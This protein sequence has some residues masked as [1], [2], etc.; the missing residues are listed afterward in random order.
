MKKTN[1]Y[2]KKAVYSLIF[3]VGLLSVWTVIALIVNDDYSM[4]SIIK[5][6]EDMFKIFYVQEF[7]F[8]YFSTLLRAGIGFA[9]SFIIGFLL[10]II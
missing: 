10:A 1:T 9:C 8:A 7:A 6:A 2:I 3:I 5:I 4:P